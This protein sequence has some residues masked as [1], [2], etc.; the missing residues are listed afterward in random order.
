[1]FIIYFDF[2][3]VKEANFIALTM[4]LCLVNRLLF[5]I[6]NFFVEEKRIASCI[7]LKGIKKSGANY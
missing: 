3:E 5:S 6:S 7:K 4:K 2:E 1:M